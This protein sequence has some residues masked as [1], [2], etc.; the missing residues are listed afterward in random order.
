MSARYLAEDRSIAVDIEDGA[1]EVMRRLCSQAGRL[2]TGGVLIGRYS[3]SG[4]RVVV[5]EVLAAAAR[6]ASFPVFV[7]PWHQGLDGPPAPRMATGHVL[8]RRVALP[9]A[10]LAYPERHGPQANQGIMSEVWLF[11]SFH[12]LQ[13]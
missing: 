7:H 4:D 3:E 10:W 5:T 11:F 6:L 13:G 1:L 9:P 8:R 12:W 2:E